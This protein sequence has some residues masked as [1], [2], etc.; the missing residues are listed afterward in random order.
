[1]AMIG[2]NSGDLNIVKEYMREI[3]VML[4]QIAL[5]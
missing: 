3:C 4:E 1:M 5:S 2:N